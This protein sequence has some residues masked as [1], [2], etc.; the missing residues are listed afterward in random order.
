MPTFFP[1]MVFHAL[2]HAAALN[3][4]KP[5][6]NIYIRKGRIARWQYSRMLAE[7]LSRN[8]SAQNMKKWTSVI[9]IL[10]LM[11]TAVLAQQRRVMLAHLANCKKCRT[12]LSGAI[13][14]Q[15]FVSDP[16]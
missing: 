13:L 9:I 12:I 2:F 16:G 11:D 8:L 7:M 15:S 10:A 6:L 5:A 4:D 14:S 3:Q 1:G